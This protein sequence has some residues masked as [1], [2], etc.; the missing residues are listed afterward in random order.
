[1][2]DDKMFICSVGEPDGDG[3]GSCYCHGSPED[4][5]TRLSSQ[6]S[7]FLWFDGCSDA[8]HFRLDGGGMRGEVR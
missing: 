7:K 3:I 8:S 1:M 5:K 4:G 6:S 2:S